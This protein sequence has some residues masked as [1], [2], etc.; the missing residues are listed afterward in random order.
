MPDKTARQEAYRRYIR[1]QIGLLNSARERDWRSAVD[2]LVLSLHES[3]PLLIESVNQGKVNTDRV[4]G[5]ANFL[6]AHGMNAEAESLFRSLVR[7]QP[8]NPAY[9]NDLAVVLLRIGDRDRLKEAIDLLNRAVD[10]DFERSGPKATELPAFKNREIAISFFRVSEKAALEKEELPGGTLGNLETEILGTYDKLALAETAL[11]LSEPALKYAA[12]LLLGIF[13]PLDL[14]LGPLSGLFGLKIPGQ[15]Y[16]LVY[17]LCVVLALAVVYYLG[18][19]CRNR[20]NFVIETRLPH[21]KALVNSKL[22]T[23]A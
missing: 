12:L 13:T 6:S 11:K 7:S 23:S 9:L 21:Y 3:V 20:A 19:R 17:S 16:T 8:D 4:S 10:I 1:G 18:T 14:V 5:L 2:S 22:R 15:P